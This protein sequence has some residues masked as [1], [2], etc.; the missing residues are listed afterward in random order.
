MSASE[1]GE[2]R[3]VSAMISLLLLAMIGAGSGGIGGALTNGIDGFMV[4][5]CAGFILGVVAWITDSM[6]EQRKQAWQA[7]QLQHE[8]AHR[9]APVYDQATVRQAPPER[10]HPS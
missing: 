4:G 2:A 7:E 6:A 9:A 8:F 1:L 5:S 3:T 10:T